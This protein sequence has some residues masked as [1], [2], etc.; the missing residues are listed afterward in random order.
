MH[1]QLSDDHQLLQQL[2]RRFLETAMLDRGIRDLVRQGGSFD[3]GIW[4]RGVD[5]GWLD[6]LVPDVGREPDAVSLGVVL[7][8]LGRKLVPVPLIPT[9]VAAYALATH[10][11][12]DNSAELS[13]ELISGRAAVVDGLETA[14][15]LSDGCEV[16]IQP[17][18]D[19][20]RATGRAPIVMNAKE[21]A[22]IF[23]WGAGPEGPLQGVVSAGTPGVTV[24]GVTGLDV[25]RSFA[26]I[27]LDGVR[28]REGAVISRP[29]SAHRALELQRNL[30]TAL[31]CAETIGAAEA[32]LERTIEYTKT[33][34]AFGR[35]IG[36]FQALKHRMADMLLWL[37]TAKAVTLVALQ[38]LSNGG[39]EQE[40]VSVAAA[41]ISESIPLIGRDCL[42]MHGGLG[43]TWEHEAHLYLR[44]IE[45]NAI[46]VG[47]TR[48][49]HDYLREVIGA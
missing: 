8:E 21:A 25:T 49:H 42:Q 28:V 38:R 18:S 36:S 39:D 40:A 46:L 48:R 34:F 19:G 16:E 2:T 30:V 27:E 26:T 3:E 17:T 20:F 10:S 23:V 35:S 24:R 6:L 15:G 37:E 13:K 5:A 31:L 9:A 11:D 1:R 41:Y 7:Q 12:G 43:F 45:A 4:R 33:R 44:R 29:P 32:L 22:L 47:P 14:H